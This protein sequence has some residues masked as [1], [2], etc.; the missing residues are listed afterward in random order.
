MTRPVLAIALLA[1]ASV[2]AAEPRA[3]SVRKNERDGQEYGFVPAG[4]FQMGCVPGDRSCDADEKPRHRVD[5]KACWMGRTEV[6]VEA[7]KRYAAATQR[8]MPAGP[9]FDLQ[10]SRGD[11]PIVGVTWSEAGAYC[12][13]A[14]GRLPSESEWERAARGGREGARYPWGSEAPVCVMGAPKPDRGDQLPASWVMFADCDRPLTAPVASYRHNAYSLFDLAGNVME[15]TQDRFH[16]TYAGAPAD[17]KAWETGEAAQRVVRGGAWNTEAPG[18]RASQRAVGTASRG[19]P[20]VGFRCVM[21]AVA[22]GAA[23]ARA[24]PP[25][26]PLGR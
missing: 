16:A 6:T 15:W 11:H 25:A 23:V 22:A 7:W 24:Q 26:A 10:W 19:Y 1:A 17:G 2:S 14:G 8:A 20:F 18:L 3:G 5:V 12:A 21:D 13:W 9:E 4:R